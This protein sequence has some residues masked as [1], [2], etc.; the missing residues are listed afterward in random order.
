M[1]DYFAESNGKKSERINIIPGY[2][3]PADME[4]IKRMCD[5]TGV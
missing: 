2:V 1:V 3:E 5:L 4:E